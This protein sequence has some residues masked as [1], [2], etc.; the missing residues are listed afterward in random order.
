MRLFNICLLAGTVL[1]LAGCKMNLDV[2]DF[3]PTPVA[4]PVALKYSPGQGRIELT[5]NLVDRPY[6]YLIERCVFAYAATPSGGGLAWHCTL[7]TVTGKKVETLLVFTLNTDSRGKIE[8]GSVKVLP[9][10]Q[11]PSPKMTDL[12]VNMTSAVFHS[13]F[14]EYSN[15]E[16][17]GGMTAAS[18]AVIAQDLSQFVG[19]LPMALQG[20]ANVVGT[21]CYV[22]KHASVIPSFKKKN[23]DMVH[24]EV[25]TVMAL[26]AKTLLPVRGESVVKEYLDKTGK[27]NAVYLH[28][29]RVMQPGE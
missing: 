25:E 29:L 6:E 3:H 4:G 17:R 27:L 8:P 5:T 26:D 13:V 16:V 10:D 24:D 18:T 7:E 28:T 20:R 21:D 1:L 12:T 14:P 2:V 22:L 23:R 15:Q 11:K 9:N 19:N